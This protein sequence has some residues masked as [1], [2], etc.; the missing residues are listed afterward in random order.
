[1]VVTARWG[2]WWGVGLSPAH[3]VADLGTGKQA[4]PSQTQPIRTMSQSKPGGTTGRQAV[5]SNNQLKYNQTHR[6]KTDAWPEVSITSGHLPDAANLSPTSRTNT[7]SRSY[8]R[9]GHMLIIDLTCATGVA[10]VCHVR[11]CVLEE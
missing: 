11:P 4:K 5:Q 1:M 6:K 10:S 7:S 9:V 2:G 3:I 8:V